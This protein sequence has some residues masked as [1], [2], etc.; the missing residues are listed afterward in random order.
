M[1]LHRKLAQESVE[2]GRLMEGVE[3]RRHGLP[4]EARGPVSPVSE[5]HLS[6]NGSSFALGS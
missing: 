1:S 3:S 5:F 2:R 4:Q 6:K